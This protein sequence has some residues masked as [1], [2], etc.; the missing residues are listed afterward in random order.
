[1]RHKWIKAKRCYLCNELCDVKEEGGCLLGTRF[2][3][4]SDI[5][6]SDVFFCASCTDKLKK[7]IINI[8][9]KQEEGTE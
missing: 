3:S 8:R 1:M 2:S 4:F 9:T 6:P 7:Y 5:A